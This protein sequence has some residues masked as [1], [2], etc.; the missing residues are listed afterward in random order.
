MPPLSSAPD[1]S[2]P[3]I[4]QTRPGSRWRWIL[5]GLIAVCL[6]VG[7]VWYVARELE[8]TRGYTAGHIYLVLGAVPAGTLFDAGMPE[9][10]TVL[11][12]L[13]L[14]G[15]DGEILDAVGSKDATYYLVMSEDGRTSNVY[16]YSDGDLT[17]LTASQTMKYGLSYDPQSG[18]FAYLSSVVTAPLRGQTLIEQFSIASWKLTI[19]TS[20]GIEKVL[21]ASGTQ[22]HLL[23]G[24]QSL[25]LTYAGTTGVLDIATGGRTEILGHDGV[26]AVSVDGT[27]LAIY[28]KVTR[29]VDFYTLADRAL[30]YARS[31][32][33]AVEPRV[34]VY[35]DA[36]VLLSYTDERGIVIESLTSGATLKVMENPLPDQVVHKL[37]L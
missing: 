2:P 16:T 14:S 7:A 28:N 23:P 1:N 17:P 9:D 32:Q 37:A 36:D 20:D 8:D 3:Y 31:Q 29:A 11:T 26:F 21:D 5:A 24:G 22:P 35:K 27:S 10:D 15:V 6:V 13:S 30:S 18:T 25:V 4:P 19:L 12:P 33:V 34:L